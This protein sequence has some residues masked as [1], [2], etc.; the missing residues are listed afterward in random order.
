MIGEA[1]YDHTFDLNKGITHWN[2]EVTSIPRSKND[3]LN[4]TANSASDGTTAFSSKHRHQK[5][6]TNPHMPS[7][8]WDTFY[9]RCLNHRDKQQN[10]PHRTLNKT[11]PTQHTVCETHSLLTQGH[12]N[13]HNC[14]QDTFLSN[15]PPSNENAWSAVHHNCRQER[16]TC[17]LL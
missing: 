11:L 13:E 10:K 12:S 17:E 15:S 4:R 16:N 9:R 7:P 6:T 14:S 1:T 2:C 5:N 3:I 8:T